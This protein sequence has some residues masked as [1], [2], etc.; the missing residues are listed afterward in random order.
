MSDLR[1]FRSAT[2]GEG[3]AG[4]HQSAS[5]P[6]HLCAFRITAAP[7]RRTRAQQRRRT[8]RSSSE[9]T[10]QA[11]LRIEHARCRQGDHAGLQISIVQVRLRS[12]FFIL[13]FPA[14]THL[15]RTLI[16]VRVLYTV[17]WIRLSSFPISCPR[18]WRGTRRTRI[19]CTFVPRRTGK[20]SLVSNRCPK[21]NE[22][23]MK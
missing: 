22:R 3:G 4:T 10:E 8:S 7:T 2:L 13:V 16:G 21:R 20:R 15:Y 11:V 14:P 18:C 6:L 1:R 23:M 19:T 9:S 17:A 12:Y 5:S